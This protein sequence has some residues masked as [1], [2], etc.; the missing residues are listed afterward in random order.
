MNSLRVLR[1][2]LKSLRM[3]YLLSVKHKNISAGR[4]VYFGVGC[5][6]SPTAKIQIKNN[7][8]IGRHC[9]FGAQD[10]YIGSCVMIA[11]YVG[12]VERAAHATNIVGAAFI[13]T[14]PNAKIKTEVLPTIIE[15]DVWIGFGAILLSGVT[16]GEGAIV[17]A[18]SVVVDDVPPYSIVA[19]S[20]AK[21]IS[22]RFDEDEILMHKERLS[23][24]L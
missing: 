24:K 9:Q 2:Q 6:F 19:S 4:E 18:G 5:E 12:V 17:A 10:L 1:E 22:Y 21:P 8:A 20:K 13:E 11:S 14:G 15:N 3:L 7:V 23:A 16:V